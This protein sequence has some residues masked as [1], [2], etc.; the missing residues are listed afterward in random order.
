MLEDSE[1]KLVSSL[2][3]NRRALLAEVLRFRNTL[4]ETGRQLNTIED[5]VVL[6]IDKVLNR[7]PFAKDKIVLRRV[8]G[9]TQ[10][11][12][13]RTDSFYSTY[14]TATGIGEASNTSATKLESMKLGGKE[15]LNNSL[16]QPAGPNQVEVR[17]PSDEVNTLFKELE[18]ANIPV[19]IQLSYSKKGK[20]RDRITHKFWMFLHPK[21]AGNVVIAVTGPEYEWVESGVFSFDQKGRNNHCNGDCD[22]DDKGDWPIGYDPTK[23]WYRRD[24]KGFRAPPN[25]EGDIKLVKASIK[26]DEG[27]KPDHDWDVS[28]QIENNG[29]TLAG[30]WKPRTHP[31]QYV[32][33]ATKLRYSVKNPNAEFDKKEFD[34]E[35]GKIYSYQTKKDANSPTVKARFFAGANLEEL[36]NTET[37][38]GNRLEV[39]EIKESGDFRTY[40]FRF[41]PR[42]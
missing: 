38:L 2:D 32:I 17:L 28:A 27:G 15:L 7:V 22:K 3:K 29:K 40:S 9:T 31:N 6:D 25:K 24:V 18:V 5:D 26:L 33:S 12:S 4:E 14:L 30:G 23:D 13:D 16:V 42:D 35:Y 10:I 39:L 1:D 19:E 8:K 37:I 36:M 34:Y 11:Y 20:E 41:L 21:I